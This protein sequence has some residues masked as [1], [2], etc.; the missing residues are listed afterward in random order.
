MGE[1]ADKYWIFT[2]G[3]GQEH[4]G[5]YVK[6][7]AKSRGEAW[8]KMVERYGVHWAFQY[9]EEEWKTMEDNPNRMYPMEKFLCS[10]E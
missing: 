6:V 10:I 3:Y 8:A 4:A 2:F 7:K 1:E 9:T 5:T